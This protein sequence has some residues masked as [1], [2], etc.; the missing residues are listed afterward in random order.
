MND[1]SNDICPKCS[2]LLDSEGLCWHCMTKEY[3]KT[4]A[5]VE[6][7]ERDGIK[8]WATSVGYRLEIGKMN[9]IAK[10]IG[11]ELYIDIRD[12]KQNQ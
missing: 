3:N 9:R 8:S 2:K 7:I 6:G 12:R 1:K 5:I 10:K 4:K 11:K